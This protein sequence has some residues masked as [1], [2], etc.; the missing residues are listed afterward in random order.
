MRNLR[1]RLSLFF[2][3]KSNAALDSLEDPVEVLDY[4]YAEQ[5]VHL[6]SVRR[7]LVEVAAA[8]QQ[9]EQQGERLRSRAQR[10]EEQARRALR[11]NREDLARR[12]LERKQAALAEIGSLDEQRAAIAR[13]EERLRSAEQQVAQ[14]VERFKFHRSVA[15]A[16]Y[17][18][19]EAQVGVGEALS[20]IGGLVSEETELSLAVERSEER[21]EQM[22]ARAV[23]ITA[24]TESGVLL[25]ETPAGDPVERELE[26]FESAEAVER[27]L[28]ALRREISEEGTGSRAQTE[29]AAPPVGGQGVSGGERRTSSEGTASAAQTE[30]PA[31]PVVAQGGGGG[32]DEGGAEKPTAGE[33]GEVSDA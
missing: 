26:A 18:A 27:E 1:S 31:P 24:L 16:R 30:P 29:P 17:A 4:A 21:I 10:F 6:R 15:A 12:A 19:A 22:S 32:A 2:N 23:A 28:E 20:G 11:G 33:G 8:R 9:L 14:R 5:Q 7:G 25:G 3:I 13:D